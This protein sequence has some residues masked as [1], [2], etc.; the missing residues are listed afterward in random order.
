MEALPHTNSS[1][2]TASN[3]TI[4]NSTE[5]SSPRQSPS[6]YIRPHSEGVALTSQDPFDDIRRVASTK[7]LIAKKYERRAATRK[8]THDDS[9]PRGDSGLS[10][11]STA[12]SDSLRH[13]NSNASLGQPSDTNQT[14]A[15]VAPQI[16]LS[17]GSWWP[18]RG[19]AVHKPVVPKPDACSDETIITAAAHHAD[20]QNIGWMRRSTQQ[21][22]AQ[23]QRLTGA[24]PETPYLVAG[25]LG[26]PLVI[27]GLTP[28]RNA[29]TLGAQNKTSSMVGLYRQVYELFFLRFR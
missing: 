21:L 25:A 14:D 15:P 17:K 23:R 18:S 13:T 29:M 16:Q 5:S 28:F 27:S 4:D 19:L 10:S 26:G 1:S 3:V 7:G 6:V 22:S 9:I 2:S 11:A 24:M 20:T 12:A 8:R